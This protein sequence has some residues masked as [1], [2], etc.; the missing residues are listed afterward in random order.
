ML[1]CGS[2]QGNFP[3]QGGSICL[4][5]SAAL[6]ELN[7]GVQT[8]NYCLKREEV[9]WGFK[10]FGNL[11][12]TAVCGGTIGGVRGLKE[13]HQ[14]LEVQQW[15]WGGKNLRRTYGNYAYLRKTG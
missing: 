3:G 6:T 9:S 1:V 12:R 10:R 2:R 13:K 8:K 4:G 14:K 11:R 15:G 5:H 7:I